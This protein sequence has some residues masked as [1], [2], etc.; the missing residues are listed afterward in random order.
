[1]KPFRSARFSFLLLSIGI[2]LSS[3]EARAVRE[4]R[5]FPFEDPRTDAWLFSGDE[6]F[7]EIE[8]LSVRD[9][10]ATNEHPPLVTVKSRVLRGRLP[11]GR[12]VIEWTPTPLFLFCGVGE[13]AT[14]RRWK[15]HPLH[16][17]PVGQRLV[18]GGVMGPQVWMCDQTMRWDD[19]NHAADPIRRKIIEW[20]PNVRARQERERPGHEAARR[21][22]AAARAKAEGER[23]Q[24]ESRWLETARRL[25][26]EADLEAL[27]RS[28]EAICLAPVPRPGPAR[29]WIR[30]LIVHPRLW[31]VAPPDSTL[32]RDSIEVL[33]RAREDSL[34][35]RWLAAPADE[36]PGSAEG[37]SLLGLYFLRSSGGVRERVLWPTD[38]EFGILPANRDLVRRTLSAVARRGHDPLEP[39]AACGSSFSETRPADD[40][41]AASACLKLSHRGRWTIILDGRENPSHGDVARDPGWF[42]SCAF[43]DDDYRTEFEDAMRFAVGP[44][45]LREMIDSLASMPEFASGRIEPGDS[46]AVS[47]RRDIGGAPR[48]YE[49]TLSPQGRAALCRAMAA[50]FHD[51]DIVRLNVPWQ[52]GRV[53]PSLRANWEPPPP[54]LTVKLLLGPHSRMPAGTGAIVGL[55]VDDETEEGVF[56]ATVRISE[57]DQVCLTGFGGEFALVDL[58]PG[59]R[60]VQVYQ[61]GYEMTFTEIA[62]DTGKVQ[63]R[64]FRLSPEKKSTVAIRHA[65]WPEMAVNAPPASAP[66]TVHVRDTKGAPVP[67]AW[68]TLIR[69]DG[70]E[71]SIADVD[72]H[73]SFPRVLPGRYRLLVRKRG[74]APWAAPIDFRAAAPSTIETRLEAR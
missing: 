68:L 42:V 1:M 45:K 8:V 28:S 31:L 15:D 50:V 16:G 10:G 71:S 51:T 56:Q 73:G 24:S 60:L 21:A 33:F 6:D 34:G 7:L 74:F 35:R 2:A 58:P 40:S 4:V 61:A 57:P 13:G 66:I 65:A 39:V 67:D 37:D 62:P 63:T 53:A 48:F 36:N 44:A 23:V 41:E 52:W 20:E 5:G 17:P 43:R 19:T 22:E 59:R 32:R 29:P 38:P 72:G 70:N 25:R 69:P 3:G 47:L 30:S 18:V 49:V 26:D 55:V 64:I 54:P 12:R 14:I 11:G 46:L 27:V 9:S